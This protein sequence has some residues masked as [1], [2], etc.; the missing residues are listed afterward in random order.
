MP[1]KYC[2]YNAVWGRPYI[3]PFLEISLP[4]FLAPGNI[5]HIAA[6]AETTYVLYTEEQDI[7]YVRAAP[8]FKRLES[9]VTVK[10]I[11]ISVACG[12]DS[13]DLN[14][15]YRVASCTNHCIRNFVDS[16]T[17]LVIAVPDC[18]FSDGALA[19][20]H[21]RLSKGK[22][23][24]ACT[25]LSV[26]KQ[27]F[28]A[29]LPQ[30]SKSDG[31]AIS[32]ASKDLAFLGVKH[33]HPM[34]QVQ[35]WNSETGTIWP[36]V[37]HWQ[38]PGEGIIAH[39]LHYHPLVI[40]PYMQGLTSWG[41]M[42][43]LYVLRAC[44]RFED[45]HFVTDSDEL[46]GFSFTDEAYPLFHSGTPFSPELVDE[47]AKRNAHIHQR[48]S[49]THAVRYHWGP[50]SPEW[51]RIEKEA[52]EAVLQMQCTKSKDICLSISERPEV[53]VCLM[54]G[55]A[56]GELIETLD[57]L[58]EGLRPPR[59]VIVLCDKE[60]AAKTHE[61]RPQFKTRYVA[62]DSSAPQGQVVRTALPL[63]SSECCAFLQSG[64]S[65]SAQWLEAAASALARHPR[66][67]M[68]LGNVATLDKA[69]QPS[70][71]GGWIAHSEA[72]LA[73]GDFLQLIRRAGLFSLLAH[74][75]PTVYRT[76]VLLQALILDL[77]MKQGTFSFLTQL[78]GLVY[79]SVYVN[80]ICLT[81]AKGLAEQDREQFQHDVQVQKAYLTHLSPTM[82]ATI[83]R[84]ICPSTGPMLETLLGLSKN[85]ESSFEGV[86]PLDALSLATL[87]DM[88]SY[89][90]EGTPDF[91]VR[92]TS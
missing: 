32:I 5:P 42:D 69:G 4:S 60:E 83:D 7:E 68:C 63:I 36:S 21:E 56:S 53:S 81:A 3:D 52:S 26:L 17:A 34:F 27:S 35:E 24:I 15:Y 89:A 11:P 88:I 12:G 30:H 6:R 8:S 72:E 1:K 74:P 71:V 43:A 20:A 9:I 50:L 87:S 45:I 25:G 80:E 38:V 62:V 78:I 82:M 39:T 79:S 65:P 18:V 28:I 84:C 13:K 55:Y 46:C 77:P 73:P 44:P 19:A 48:M 90:A 33:L 29:E 59:E 66:V 14:K 40:Q 64:F 76:G 61:R 70:V 85:A 86:L 67:Q 22:R 31:A 92:R 16:D 23:L 57:A 49:V 91:L 54:P 37:L 41:T 51:H 58:A 75:Q 10:I 47:W 2:I